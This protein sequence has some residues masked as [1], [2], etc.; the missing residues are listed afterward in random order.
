MR[1][2]PCLF[3]AE[4][5]NSAVFSNLSLRLGY[6]AMD[7]ISAEMGDILALIKETRGG[8]TCCGAC[9]CLPALRK[10]VYAL[11]S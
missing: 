1:I 8:S 9:V 5:M 3:Q 2:F 7:R 10:H 4:M 6:T 11:S